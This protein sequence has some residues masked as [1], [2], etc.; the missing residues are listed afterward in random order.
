[1]A[2]ATTIYEFTPIDSENPTNHFYFFCRSVLTYYCK[3]E[4]KRD[5]PLSTL[6]GKVVLIVNTASECG[7]RRHLEGLETLYKSVNATHPNSFVVLGFPSDHFNQEPREGDELQEF[8]RINYGVSFPLL[9]R[10]GLNGK[11]IQRKDGQASPEPKVD[12]GEAL[13]K[14]LGETKPGLFGMKGMRWNFEKFLIG[15]DGKVKQRYLP[16]SSPSSLESDILAEI[17]AGK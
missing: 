4:Q 7:L 17:K 15:K 3:L 12:G 9:G 2:S 13:F 16:L 14:W 6:K 1:M 8:C 5:Y 11:A 10:I